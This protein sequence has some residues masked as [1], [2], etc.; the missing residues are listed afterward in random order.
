MVEEFINMYARFNILLLSKHKA[1]D[2]FRDGEVIIIAR[3][4]SFPCTKL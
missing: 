2:T 3:A 4:T 1:V